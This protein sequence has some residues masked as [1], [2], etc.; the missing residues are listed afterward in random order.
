MPDDAG[1]HPSRS[2]GLDFDRHAQL[3]SCPLPG[4]GALPRGPVAEPHSFRP[5]CAGGHGSSAN[6]GRVLRRNLRV[7][8]LGSCR[9][10]LEIMVVDEL[11]TALSGASGAALACCFMAAAVALHWSGRRTARGAA[12]RARQRQQAALESM[13]KAAQRFR[14]QV[15]VEVGGTGWGYS[16]ST[17]CCPDSWRGR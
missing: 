2:I 6:P 11:W 16:H 13:D 8:A 12:A 10:R 7:L 4:N 14:L 1:G 5:S 9:R 15:T 3:A 17:Y